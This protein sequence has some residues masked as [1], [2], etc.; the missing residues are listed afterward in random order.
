MGRQRA[1]GEFLRKHR[2]LVAEPAEG[3][4][5]AFH[6]GSLMHRSASKLPTVL[7]Q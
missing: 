3:K 4:K 6:P 2:E 1:L 5:I 7:G